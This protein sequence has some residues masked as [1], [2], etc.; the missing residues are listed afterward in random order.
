M[1]LKSLTVLTGPHAYHRT[2]LWI[3][4]I[5]FMQ[6]SCIRA[7]QSYHHILHKTQAAFIQHNHQ[8]SPQSHGNPPI[9]KWQCSLDAPVRRCAPFF[10]W[11][12]IPTCRPN[13]CICF[14]TARLKPPPPLAWNPGSLHI[15]TEPVNMIVSYTY[16]CCI[17]SLS[18]RK[19]VIYTVCL[20]ARHYKTAI[21]GNPNYFADC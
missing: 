13:A 1:T 4:L 17:L 11:T 21:S 20:T 3:F 18:T 12:W 2:V 16:S 9:S 8:I 6:I 5:G 14:C 10:Q 15:I 19:F 7:W